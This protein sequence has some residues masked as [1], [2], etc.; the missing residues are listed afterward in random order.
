VI[1]A[2]LLAWVAGCAT[3]ALQDP[4][5]IAQRASRIYR[6][7]TS[8]RADFHQVIEDRMIG[9]QES[10]GH[11][12]Q[13]GASKLAMRFTDPEGDAIVLDG[14]SVWIYTPSTT[15]G[16]VIRSAIP[17]DPVYGPNVLARILDRPTERY[18]L[19]YLRPDTLGAQVVDVV[20]FI[21]AVEDPLFRRAVIWFDRAAGLPRRL[22]L[23]EIGGVQRML[24]LFRIRLNL[25][26][27]AETF[28]FRVPPG[29][30]VVER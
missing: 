21:P 8:I 28:R 25:P 20:E 26:V 23:Q 30:R 5:A 11:L 24:D 19:G 4:A 14:T 15:P 1:A 17:H 18:Q 22:E 13:S 16:Q 3:V 27:S 2:P 29:V 9:A 7:L 6:N 12:V 10:R